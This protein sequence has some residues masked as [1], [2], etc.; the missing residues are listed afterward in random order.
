MIVELYRVLVGKIVVDLAALGLNNVALI[1]GA[2][3]VQLVGLLVAALLLDLLL[4][5]PG[6]L[7]VVHQALGGTHVALA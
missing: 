3:V 7:L 2:R 1:W 6:G 5:G 4:V